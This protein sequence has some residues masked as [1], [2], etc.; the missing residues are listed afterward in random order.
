MAK[1]IGKLIRFLG[2]ALVV[3]AQPGDAT[4]HP[5]KTIQYM[6]AD[7]RA[8]IFFTL[9][10]V[11]EADPVAPS[12]PWFALPKSSSNFAELNAMLLS[13]K[14]AGRNVSIQTDGTVSCGYA[15]ATMVQLDERSDWPAF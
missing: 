14:L 9:N 4:G 11:G 6:L 1:A 12:Q 2:V 13:A 8:C 10:G 7:G 15:A 5:G 3:A